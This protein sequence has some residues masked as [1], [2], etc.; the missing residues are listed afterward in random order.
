MDNIIKIIIVVVIVICAFGYLSIQEERERDTFVQC[1]ADADNIMEMESNRV[2][3]EYGKGDNCSVL[4][5]PKEV[6]DGVTRRYL[7]DRER[8]QNWYVGKGGLF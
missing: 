2:C 4:D 6:L 7:A 1:K 5:I 3:H 8:C